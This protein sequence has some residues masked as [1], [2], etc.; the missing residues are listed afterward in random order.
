MNLTDTSFSPAEQSPLIPSPAD[1]ADDQPQGDGVLH[2]TMKVQASQVLHHD[3]VTGN[4]ETPG[5]MKAKSLGQTSGPSSRKK[6]QDCDSQFQ[7]KRVNLQIGKLPN[8]S[9]PLVLLASFRANHTYLARLTSA[10][11][12]SAILK[13]LMLFPIIL[14]STE[15]GFSPDF[16]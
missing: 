11:D 2:S 9:E 14:G 15:D 1:H 13:M 5:G 12:K 8:L 10:L 16:S 3:D 7:Y 4:D 6:P